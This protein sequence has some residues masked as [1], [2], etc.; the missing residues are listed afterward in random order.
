VRVNACTIALLC[1]LLWVASISALGP[2]RQP[3][4]HLGETTPLAVLMPAREQGEAPIAGNYALPAIKLAGDGSVLDHTGRTHRLAQFTSGRITLLSFIFSNC[5]DPNGCPLAMGT[6][7]EIYHASENSK[8]LASNAR[9]VTLSFDPERDTPEALASYAEAAIADP[10]GKRKVPWLFLTTRSKDE[11]KPILE[12]Y[13]QPVAPRHRSDQLNHLLRLYLIDRQGRV[14][15]IYGLGMLDPAFLLADIET[16]LLED[17]TL[18][19]KRQ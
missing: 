5:S 13:G 16:L 12:R 9:L 18:G 17:G 14:R 1:A 10:D 11:L 6:L 7:F 4:A 15:N 8:V 2:V 3:H 19:A